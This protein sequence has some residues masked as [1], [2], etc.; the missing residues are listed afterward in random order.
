MSEGE[1]LRAWISDRRQDL[2]VRLLDQARRG[3]FGP[4]SRNR[5]ISELARLDALEKVLPPAPQR[6]YNW[7]WGLLAV[8]L[9]SLLLAILTLP[10][11]R[12]G[13]LALSAQAT[14]MRL[15][16]ADTETMKSVHPVLKGF[17]VE[18]VTDV[19]RIGDPLSEKFFALGQSGRTLHFSGNAALAGLGCARACEITLTTSPGGRLVISLDGAP[20][21]D[22]TP[23]T[24]TIRIDGRNDLCA[25]DKTSC[26]DVDRNVRASPNSK[27]NIH[28]RRATIPPG[29]DV[30]DATV[31]RGNGKFAQLAFDVKSGFEG[32]PTGRDSHLRQ[33]SIQ[34]TSFG[35][36]TLTRHWGQSLRL[37]G[38]EGFL[39]IGFADDSLKVRLHGESGGIFGSGDENLTPSTLA[40][41]W[42]NKTIAL[43]FGAFLGIFGFMIDKFPKAW[44]WMRR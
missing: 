44:E 8:G 5:S 11:I 32:L 26:I 31:I 12:P 36:E 30:A 15:K 23:N 35:D 2:Y 19:T 6:S 39:D 14:G 40:W 34:L 18:K 38:V 13:G 10:H 29:A 37:T 27:F 43:Y 1:E 9:A 28:L 25:D 16:P 17:S 41:L 21:V 33:A 20:Y 22:V 3:T 42:Q 24:S 7:R 4:S